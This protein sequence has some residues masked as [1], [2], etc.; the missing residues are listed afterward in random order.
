[1]SIASFT[2]KITQK[3][4]GILHPNKKAAPA[5]EGD[6]VNV[7]L[8]THRN[9]D[10][11]GDQ[12]IEACDVS[13][14]T[15]VMKSL[16]KN[17][18]IN[19]SG[20]G[21][22]S[23][24]YLESMDTALLAEAERV[25]QETDIVIFGGAPVFN[26]LYQN[27]Y[28][29]TAAMIEIARKY[30]KPV[31]FSAIGVEHYDE[32]D[33]RCQYLK[34]TLNYDCVKQITT[35]DDFEML[36]KYKVNENLLVEKAADPAVFA[37][38]IFEQFKSE[39][40]Q[41]K[42]GIFVLRRNGF[43]DNG[44]PFTKEESAVLWLDLIHKLEEQGY[45]Y[46]LLTSGYCEDEAFLEWMIRKYGVN[47][48]KC[49][50]HMDSPEKLVRKISSYEAVVSCRLHPSIVAFALDVPSVGIVWNSKVR[51]FYRSIGYEDRIFETKNIQAEEIV[52]KL[53]QIISEG[54]QKSETFLMSIY[55]TLFYGLASALEIEKK[56]LTPWSYE[57]LM[58][59]IPV[60][61]ESS[62]KKQ[63]RR[64]RKKFRRI[65]KIYNECLDD[66]E[67]LEKR[68]KALEEENFRLKGRR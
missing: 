59:E 37:G 17:C 10:N 33:S 8:L 19:S 60:H 56:D 57:K 65:Y 40:Q 64:T 6:C 30:Q 7:L 2:K 61:I 67:A 66:M 12:M 31:L 27:F 46:E 45:D 23:F 41:K 42:I 32:S 49:V 35:R 15:A 4:G 51:G 21:M 20:V 54:V 18:R 38:K 5:E 62:A 1:M 24:R 13:L 58:E 53:E 16:N 34:K 39:K 3:D 55:Q 44:V 63:E 47:I 25:I 26:Y 29:R 28:K 36:K 68:V 48:N 11:T 52:L 14:I 22:V 50:F 9:S 43:I